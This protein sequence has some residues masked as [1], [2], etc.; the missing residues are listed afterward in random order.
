[1]NVP[2]N[3]MGWLFI[4]TSLPNEFRMGTFS[5]DEVKVKSYEGRAR[6]LLPM[7]SRK[8]PSAT[9]RQLDGICVV[10]GPGSFSAVR[11]GVVAA[12]ILSR[13]W[14]IPLVGVSREEAEDLAQLAQDVVT[15]K[16]LPTSY[17]MPT[18]DAEPNITIKG[19]NLHA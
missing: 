18:Y 16:K 6:E 4:D 12:N 14:R 11:G 13:A 9:V 10:Y 17:V 19:V 1:M 3:N 15:K 7:I 8:V 5:S 2:R